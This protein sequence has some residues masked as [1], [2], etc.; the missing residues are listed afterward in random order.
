MI[1]DSDLDD[2]CVCGGG[3][4]EQPDDVSSHMCVAE[5]MMTNKRQPCYNIH[6]LVMVAI[7]MSC[8]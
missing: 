3:G 8:E 5:Y 2:V 4:L 6:L 7:T 1:L